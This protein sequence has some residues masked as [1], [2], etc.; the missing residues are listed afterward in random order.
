MKVLWSLRIKDFYK[1]WIE[2]PQVAIRA[3][4]VLNGEMGVVVCQTDVCDELENI[5]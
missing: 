1:K 2:S 3:M 4:E 5:K